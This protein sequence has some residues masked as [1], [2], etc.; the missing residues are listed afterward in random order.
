MRNRIKPWKTSFL[1]EY[2]FD[3]AEFVCPLISLSR[4]YWPASKRGTIA[5]LLS[6]GFNA[7]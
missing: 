5:K 2:T 7:F 1:L 6:H 3:G 4:I